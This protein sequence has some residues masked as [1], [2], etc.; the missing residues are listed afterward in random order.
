MVE[1]PCKDCI[2]LAICKA[3][4]YQ[5]D[6]KNSRINPKTFSKCHKL[7]EYHCNINGIGMEILLT[8]IRFFFRP[9]LPPFWTDRAT[10]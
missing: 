1:I 2:T 4:S 5:Y 6:Y 7:F 10:K 3:E 9:D 8:E